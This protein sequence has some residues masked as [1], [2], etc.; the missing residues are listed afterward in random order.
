MAGPLDSASAITKLPA[1]DLDRARQ[2]YRDRLGLEAVGQE[3]SG[4]RTNG[5]LAAGVWHI[6]IRSAGCLSEGQ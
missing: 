6:L 3:R 4:R 2:F 1:Q 5:F